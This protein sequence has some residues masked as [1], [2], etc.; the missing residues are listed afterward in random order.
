MKHYQGFVGR[1]ISA[2]PPFMRGNIMALSSDPFDLLLRKFETHCVLTAADHAA[3]WA[4]PV[5][6]RQLEASSY[7]VREGERPES[8]I[9]LLTGF[10]YRHKLTGDGGR[11]IVS[12]HMPGDPLD[13]QNLYIDEADHNVQALTRVDA[14][15]LNKTDVQDLVVTHPNI[16]RAVSICSLID[17][18]I[19]REWILNV[20]R[21]DSRT[22]LA[23]LLCEFAAR[24]D[25]LGLAENYG[26]EL[27]MTQE[28]LG[29]ALG[30]TSVH[31]NRTMKALEAEG[32]IERNNRRVSFPRWKELIDV[33]DFSTRYLHLKPQIW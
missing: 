4:L 21:R 2:L 23:H 26:Y 19:F 29:D 30:L 3:I 27:P 11:Q 12:I 24:L 5:K 8:C 22:A 32:L 25:A 16:A 13:F 28:Q 7:I 14:A 18:S 15:F 17:C 10:A 1:E 6:V 33:G 20:G 9:V 31:V